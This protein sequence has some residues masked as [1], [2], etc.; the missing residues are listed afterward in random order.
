MG[1]FW[2]VYL[3]AAFLV[4]GAIFLCVVKG[5]NSVGSEWTHQGDVE[6]LEQRVE[7]ENDDDERI[8]R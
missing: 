1:D 2:P 3:A 7:L 5:G 4:F 6:M 8:V